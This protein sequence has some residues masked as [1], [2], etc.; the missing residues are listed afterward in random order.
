M[1]V[2]LSFVMLIVSRTLTLCDGETTRYSRMVQTNT[3]R[4]KQSNIRY[5]KTIIKLNLKTHKLN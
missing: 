2:F 1:N 5:P 3:A 4:G